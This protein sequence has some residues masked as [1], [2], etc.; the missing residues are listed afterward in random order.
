[1]PGH[2]A[3][4]MAWQRHDARANA[5]RRESENK[6]DRRHPA[7]G[8]RATHGS[9][10]SARVDGVSLHP[11]GRDHLGVARMGEV[12]LDPLRVE[13][14]CEPSPAEGDLEGTRASAPSSAKHDA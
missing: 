4:E 10:R 12:E 3:T 8:G 5:R 11:R 6:L 14:I 13:Q 1:V 7:G 2:P 9:R